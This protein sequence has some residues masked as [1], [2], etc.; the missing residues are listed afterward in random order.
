M[1][2]PIPLGVQ[3][4]TE[5]ALIDAQDVV[6]EYGTPIRIAIA[7]ED[8]VTRDKYNSLKKR[9]ASGTEIVD[10]KVFPLI[11]SPNIH[12]MEKAGLKEVCNCMVYTAYKDWT[13]KDYDINSMDMVRLTFMIDEQTYRVKEKTYS[14]RFASSY[15]YVVFGLVKI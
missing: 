15:L 13:D 6:N 11:D 2:L 3:L 1:R 14:D 9:I 12:Q 8:T 4:E 10:F 7:E 5:G